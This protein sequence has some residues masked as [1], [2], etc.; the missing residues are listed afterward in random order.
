MNACFV[1]RRPQVR[2]VGAAMQDD[3]MQQTVAARG[4]HHPLFAASV[5]MIHG[6][7]MIL[8]PIP[9]IPG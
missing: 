5:R 3:L 4:Q 7:L 2:R 6:A 8:V 1:M 9:D